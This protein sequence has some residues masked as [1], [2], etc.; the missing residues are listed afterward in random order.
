MYID[1]PSLPILEV[2][3]IDLDLL[4]N[5][6]PVYHAII[7]SIVVLVG[8]IVEIIVT[9]DNVVNGIFFQ[10]EEMRHMYD[11]FPEMLLNFV[12]ATYK[13]NDL[14][15]PLYL[16]LV[17]DGN[18]ESEIVA[19]WM[20][21]TEDATSIRQMAEIFKKHNRRWSDMQSQSWLINILLR[22]TLLKQSS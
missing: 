4:Y 14:R 12:D 13:L 17:E 7:P 15:M 11:R 3:T 8:S 16:F 21:V 5:L 10:D 1:A 6:Y 22:E 2:I 19:V 20:V 9:E 18:G